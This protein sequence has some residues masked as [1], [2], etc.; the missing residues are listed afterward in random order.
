MF[1]S[2]RLLMIIFSSVLI[3]VAPIGDTIADDG[4]TP[5]EEFQKKQLKERKEAED[6]R[7]YNTESSIGDGLFKGSNLI[8][9]CGKDR[10]HYACVNDLSMQNCERRKDMKCMFIQKT[11]GQR[12]CFKIQ[13]ELMLKSRIDSYCKN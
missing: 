1:I 11:K 3:V 12:E 10:R 13:S 6:F 2:T 8:Y 4:M 7:K 9:L 5:I